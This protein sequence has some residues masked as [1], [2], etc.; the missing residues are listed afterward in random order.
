MPPRA[1][2]APLPLVCKNI[3]WLGLQADVQ[4][5][6]SSEF[7]P[8]PLS[9]A[10]PQSLHKNSTLPMASWDGLATR[11]PRGIYEASLDC[12]GSFRCSDDSFVPRTSTL[13]TNVLILGSTCL[14]SI[15][16]SLFNWITS[17]VGTKT[18]SCI[19]PGSFSHLAQCCA[20]SKCF[21]YM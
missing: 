17:S 13:I 20:H 11:R 15:Y 7:P 4:A 9:L 14:F 16:P 10:T 18:I 6:A 1:C 5:Q 8:H 12:R 19:S 21:M 2:S 3:R